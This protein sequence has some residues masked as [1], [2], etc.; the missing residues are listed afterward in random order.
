MRRRIIAVTPLISLLLFLFSGLYLD[1]WSLAW[2]FFLLIPVSMILFS[3]HPLK[4]LPDMMPLIALVAFL[5]LGFGFNLW[6]PGWLVFLLI[7]LVDM[8]VERRINARKIVAVLVT[9][10]YIAIGL[11]TGKWSP[12]WIMF[13]LIPII[14]TLFF[15]R[16][17]SFISFS[18]NE[19]KNKFRH[20]IIDEEKDEDE[21]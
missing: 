6:H 7:P 20:I 1:N 9:G 3:S 2:T 19:I 16:N 15:P 12:T 5:W 8:I 17:H 21:L 4:R 11:I 10:G 13:L 18:G 14:N